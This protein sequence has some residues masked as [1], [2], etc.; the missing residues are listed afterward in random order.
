MY[1]TAIEHPEQ[2]LL[3]R[4]IAHRSTVKILNA[5]ELNSA[6]NIISVKNKYTFH[7][8]VFHPIAISHDW[9]DDVTKLKILEL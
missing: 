2:N 1:N 7:N 9:R 5:M 3:D 4:I 6:E 8:K